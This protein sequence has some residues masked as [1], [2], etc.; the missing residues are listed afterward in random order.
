MINEQ[1]TA[2]R[3]SSEVLSNSHDKVRLSRSE[4]FKTAFA[5]NIGIFSEEQQGRLAQTR[6]AIPG[7]GGVGG[8]HA[9]ALARTGIGR[10]HIADF[11][12]YDTV[13]INRQVGAVQST[14]GRLK[15]EVMAEQIKEINPYAEVSEF[16]MGVTESNLDKFLEGVDVVVD[17]LDLFQIDMRRLLFQRAREKGNLCCYRGTLRF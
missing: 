15:T 8:H 9:I 10:F 12:T 6:I 14:F 11:D 3:V 17:S 1:V 5:R 4:Y 7:L 16:A 13:N 2:D